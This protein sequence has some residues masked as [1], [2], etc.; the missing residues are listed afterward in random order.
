MP[1]PTGVCTV[2]GRRPEWLRG[3][4]GPAERWR[5]ALSVW[6]KSGAAGPA[7]WRTPHPA[8]SL[9]YGSLLRP[10]PGFTAL[11]GLPAIRSSARC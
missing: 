6:D 11:R 7:N 3:G 4:G 1:N 10:T 8:A 9:Q 5:R 2:E